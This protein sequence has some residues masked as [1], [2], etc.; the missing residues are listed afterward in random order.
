MGLFSGRKEVPMVKK[1]VLLIIRG[2]LNILLAFL[3]ILS[4]F[5]FMLATSDVP[6]VFNDQD[7]N[8]MIIL[9]IIMFIILILVIVINK[10]FRINGSHLLIIVGIVSLFLWVVTYLGCNFDLDYEATNF[11]AKK[12]INIGVIFSVFAILSQLIRIV[13]FNKKDI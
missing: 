2:V 11:Y 3:S 12:F 6:P 4:W 7:I 9:F 5:W 8:V 13:L 10:I 1:I